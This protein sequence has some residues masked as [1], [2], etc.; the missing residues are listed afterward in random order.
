MNTQNILKLNWNISFEGGT[1]SLFL[2]D[3]VILQTD[4]YSYISPPHPVSPP[5]C[6]C[7]S[8][9]HGW[10]SHGNWIFIIYQFHPYH[11]CPKFNFLYKT[12]NMWVYWKIISILLTSCVLSM[13]NRNIN[14]LIQQSSGIYPLWVYYTLNPSFCFEIYYWLD[15]V[16]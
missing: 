16:W 3:M 11:D 12:I 8:Y 14:D 15:F 7:F 6:L 4:G 10:L 2:W 5:V 1:L 13:L 9:S